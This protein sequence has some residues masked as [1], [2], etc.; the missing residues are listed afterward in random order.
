MD[1]NQIFLNA[2]AEETSNCNDGNFLLTFKKTKF[3]TLLI[4]KIIAVIRIKLK[5]LCKYIV[6]KSI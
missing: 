6:Y 2:I 1:F 5:Y 3:I 4:F